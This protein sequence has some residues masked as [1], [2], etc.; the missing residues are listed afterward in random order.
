MPKTNQFISISILLFSFTFSSFAQT[1]TTKIDLAG[2]F[3]LQFQI[4]DNFTLSSFQGG[5]FS[6]KYHFSNNSALRL[7]VTLSQSN[8]DEEYSETNVYPDIT[9]IG[10][11]EN[12]YSNYQ[13]SFS[14]QYID[15][16]KTINSIAMFY[17]GGVNYFTSPQNRESSAKYEVPTVSNSADYNNYGFGVSLLIGVE[18]FVRSNMGITAEYGTGYQYSAYEKVNVNED[19]INDISRNSKSTQTRYG[20]S[21]SSVRFGISIYF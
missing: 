6:G 12:N 10:S 11:T 9:N 8:I 2:K 19:I 18:W 1:D 14:L 5:T 13:I 15:Y 20:F 7:G 16:L 17:G 21:P 3:A 4:T